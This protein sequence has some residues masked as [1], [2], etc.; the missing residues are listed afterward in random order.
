MF[1]FFKAYNHLP[2]YIHRFSL[3]THKRL[4]IRLHVIYTPD[5]TPF[6]HR[7][8]FSYLSVVLK[9]GYKEQV[10]DNNEVVEYSHTRG[11]FIWRSN[12]TYHRI[13]EIYG[14]TYTLF[15]AWTKGGWDL[16]NHPDIVA[17][18]GYVAPSRSGIYLRNIGNTQEYALFDGFWRKG[19]MDARVAGIST[20]PSIHQVCDSFTLY[21]PL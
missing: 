2:G 20:K 9:G 11:K 4:H 7:H 15:F 21:K 16:K 1:H 6:V 3:L 13:K 8:P 10:I 17:P 12:E 14:T 18:A 5:G 19:D